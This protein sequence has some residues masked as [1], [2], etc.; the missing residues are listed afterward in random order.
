[1]LAQLPLHNHLQGASVRLHLPEKNSFQLSR[2]NR[3]YEH[4]TMQQATEAVAKMNKK[5]Y[6]CKFND[7]KGNIQRLQFESVCCRKLDRS[8]SL[9]Y[10]VIHLTGIKTRIS[11]REI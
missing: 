7:L 3:I 9:N 8:Q 10:F 11:P 2:S 4:N 6:A 1:M 5:D